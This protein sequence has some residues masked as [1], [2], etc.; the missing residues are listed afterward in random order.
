MSGSFD[1]AQICL[2]GHMINDSVKSYPLISQNFCSLCG[3]KTITACLECQNPIRGRFH[4]PN[5]ADFGEIDI[6]LF[7]IHCGAAYNWTKLRIEAAK[8]LSLEIDSLTEEDR[9]VIV[10]NLDDLVKDGPK[11]QVAAMRFKK[12][13]AKTSKEIALGL[14][15]ILID[16]VSETAKKVIWP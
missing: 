4:Y 9:N 13:A 14:K 16:I 8:E 10:N 6:P 7:C 3:S 12:V 1:T 11:T 15:E 2:Y 5:V